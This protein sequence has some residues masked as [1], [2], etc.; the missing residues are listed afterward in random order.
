MFERV[1][2]ATR[3]ARIVVPGNVVASIAFHAVAVGVAGITLPT[4]VSE[5]VTEGIVFFAP[6]PVR[7]AEPA[8]ERIAYLEVPGGGDIEASAGVPAA[9]LD[10]PLSREGQGGT[11]AADDG[12]GTAGVAALAELPQVNLDSVYFP[13][14]VDNPAAYDPR[15]AAP[16]YPDSLQRLGIEGSVTA[17][18]VVDTTG[19]AADSSF[20]IIDATHPRFAQSVREA[21]PRMLFRPAELTGVKIRQ[22]VQQTFRFQI[23]ARQNAAGDSA[24]S[25]SAPIP[26]PPAWTSGLDPRRLRDASALSRS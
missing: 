3:P 24:A 25:R 8:V 1:Y 2:P 22:L 20:V 12:V 14:E 10:G 13:D 11:Q 9:A 6:L 16:A 4:Y 7:R 5:Q 18:F 21:L 17:Q 26:I 23:P 19:R 15:S